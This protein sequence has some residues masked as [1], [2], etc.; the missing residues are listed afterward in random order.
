MSDFEQRFVDT[1]L[2]G[3]EHSDLHD[4]LI[5]LAKLEQKSLNVEACEARLDALNLQIQVRLRDSC[6]AQQR[7][8]QLCCV[9]GHEQG[10]SG[11]SA[12][13]YSP[14]NSNI[15]T[16]LRTRRGIPISLA[17]LYV[18]AARSMGWMANGV[19]FPGHFLVAVYDGA[20]TNL[21][22]GAQID[23]YALLDPFRGVTV[24]KQDCLQM[25]RRQYGESANLQE[26][27]FFAA[28]NSTFMRRMLR[29]LKQ[30]YLNRKEH[31]DALRLVNLLLKISP[32][33][34]AEL[35]DRAAILEHMQCY[36]AAAADLQSISNERP[37]HPRLSE[38]RSSISRLESLSA[39]TLH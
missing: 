25:L 1:V 12:D 14:A 18:H 39:P 29:N 23:R 2:S 37:D 9:I 26:R 7:V 27:F 13:Y 36:S 31:A 28:N 38:I 24:S 8:E 33:D 16:V 19:A 34:V 11:N 3:Q 10:F 32:T 20:P 22:G 17:F 5:L 21:Q 4:M 35:H 30:C 15:D 6:I